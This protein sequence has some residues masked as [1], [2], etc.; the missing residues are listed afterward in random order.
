MGE[1]SDI[2]VEEPLALMSV[3]HYF[4]KEGRTPDDFIQDRMQVNKGYMH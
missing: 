2:I 3:L 1:G 4:E